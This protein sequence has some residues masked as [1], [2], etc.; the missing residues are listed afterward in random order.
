MKTEVRYCSR[1]GNTKSVAE[2]IAERFGVK[3]VSIDEPGAEISEDIDLLIIGGALYAY[4]L[5]K[6]LASYIKALPEG[7]ISKA[8]VF[9]TAWLSSHAVDLISKGL[10]EKNIPVEDATL[11]V[12]SNAV[13]KS[14]EK[15]EA[16]INGL[17]GA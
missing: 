4:G 12:K 17:K 10:S 15:I 9:S 16:F 1:S 5:D 13:D 6:N 11:F 14:G 8:A 3:A 2:M 7:R